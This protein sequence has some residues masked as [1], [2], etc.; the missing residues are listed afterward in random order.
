MVSRGS[1]SKGAFRERFRLPGTSK[2]TD[3]LSTSDASI[4][5]MPISS[6]EDH[7]PSQCDEKA[8]A[9]D[10]TLPTANAN[11]P[12]S[13][14]STPQQH[15]N[16]P[17]SNVPRL[18]F[19]FLTFLVAGMNDAA[20]GALIPSIQDDYG[21]SYATV[22][23]ILL[24][25]MTGYTAS[26]LL[27]NTMHM[28][29]GQRGIGFVAGLCHIITYVVISQHP[30]FP[31]V[32][33]INTL[34]GFG[35]GLTDACY[36]AWVGSMA[37]A[38]AVQGIMHSTYSAGGVIAPLIVTGL[39]IDAQNGWWYFYYPMIAIGVLEWVGL[40]LT[41]WK[42]TGAVYRLESARI[43]DADDKSGEQQREAHVTDEE[44]VPAV[45]E[46]DETTIGPK[47][48]NPKTKKNSRTI[49]TLKSRVMWHCAIF[50]FSKSAFHCH[51]MTPSC[52]I[53]PQR[54]PH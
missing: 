34:S 30:P 10:R 13:P 6:V 25:P 12:S 29:Y 44:H 24:A 54:I 49:E 5:A 14:E 37:N 39:V 18:I 47:Q 52:P 27:N 20:I 46:S 19:A 53:P 35:N 3:V 21:L 43:E 16:Y 28:H 26:S 22:S 11:S 8:Q 38:N 48:K 17:R 32:V 9:V 51:H 2:N 4:V 36:N 42:Q 40:T 50:F 7:H 41:F 15:W 45:L 31:V 23:L 1:A 33:V